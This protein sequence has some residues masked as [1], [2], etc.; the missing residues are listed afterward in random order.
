MK[1]QHLLEWNAGLLHRIFVIGLINDGAVGVRFKRW[2]SAILDPLLHQLD[3]MG[4]MDLGLEQHGCE[5][6]GWL[7]YLPLTCGEHSVDTNADD[8]SWSNASIADGSDST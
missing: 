1:G 6:T 8:F 5:H 7:S 2:L 4:T 3:G